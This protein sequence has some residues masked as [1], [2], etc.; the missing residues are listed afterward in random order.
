MSKCWKGRAEDRPSFDD[1]YS[2]IHEIY[3]KYAAIQSVAPPTTHTHVDTNY[4]T[5]G[6]DLR[7]SEAE[8]EAAA[9]TV[10]STSSYYRKRRSQGS[11]RSSS[12]PRHSP[13][14][15]QRNSQNLLG[16]E[17][18]SGVGE[19]LSITFSVLSNENG[20]DQMSCSEDE[21]ERELNFEIP[22]FLVGGGMVGGERN[23]YPPPVLS[24]LEHRQRAESP[25]N[26][27]STFLPAGGSKPAPPP[28]D[29]TDSVTP[30]LRSPPAIAPGSSLG[31][32]SNNPSPYPPT[33][34]A[35]A[36]AMPTIISTPC[37]SYD[38]TSFTSSQ[39]G[40][41]GGGGGGRCLDNTHCNDND[42][43][44]PPLAL[45]NSVSPDLAQPTISVT[46]SNQ[47]TLST[48]DSIIAPY[49][50]D[51]SGPHSILLPAS[52]I[53]G[54]PNSTY[55]NTSVS[56]DDV[57]LRN[58]LLVDSNSHAA[59]STSVVSYTP[60]GA[61]KSDSGIRSDEEMES[62]LSNGNGGGLSSLAQPEGRELKSGP[63]RRA[64]PPPVMARKSSV[65]SVGKKDS[66]TSLGISD[67]SS[68]LMAQFASWGKN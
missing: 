47:D 43:A 38:T 62:V 22:S 26:M 65:A 24:D 32:S 42:S 23:A 2:L 53:P 56:I 68:D 13:A 18:M 30:T 59:K 1:I 31:S 33:P 61:S 9:I 7:P 19:R 10:A 39:M 34:T 51:S 44:T 57:R 52:H 8:A 28:R 12:L 21:E 29:Y 40:T 27:V 3:S 41:P 20:F 15:S 55:N 63:S 16:V 14:S 36:T 46:P 48:P 5:F 35:A 60:S 37:P 50:A 45:S 11:F 67:L 64:P 66:E 49:D 6:K 17:N 54:I 25:L 58:K 4:S